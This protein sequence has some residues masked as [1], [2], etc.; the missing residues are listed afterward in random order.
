MLEL[1][2]WCGA[3]LFGDSAGKASTVTITNGTQ[4]VAAGTGTIKMNGAT[5]RNST[6]WL[7]IYVGT[8]IK[9][10]PYFDTVTG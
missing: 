2:N 5:A 7:K 10:V 9:Y 6:G 1:A 3:D 4:G 8:S